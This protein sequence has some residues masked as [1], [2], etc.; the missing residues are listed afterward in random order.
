MDQQ[1]FLII[2]GKDIF[3]H[4]YPISPPEGYEPNGAF[5]DCC[6]FH[7]NV[8]ADT[9]GFLE[10]FPNC[11]EPHRSFAK[12]PF[13]NAG[14]YKDLATKVVNLVSYTEFKI[15]NN[16]DDPQWYKDVTDYIEWIVYSFGQPSVGLDKYLYHLKYYVETLQ[17]SFTDY[18]ADKQ[19]LLLE[20]INGL[21][22]PSKV[23]VP[24]LNELYETYNKWLNTFPFGL[25]Y[26]KN[27]KEHFKNNI[28]ILADKSEYNPYS[29]LSR[30]KLQTRASLIIFLTTATKELLK[31]IDAS[32]LVNDGTIEDPDQHAIAVIGQEHRVKQM[33]LVEQY[34][35][36]EMDYV[37]VLKKWLKN[38]VAYFAKISPLLHQKYNQSKSNE[39][40]TI[41][42]SDEIKP[43]AGALAQLGFG[44]Y[45]QTDDYDHLLLEHNFDEAWSASMNQVNPGDIILVT[46]TVAFDNAFFNLA[47]QFWAKDK[48]R[49]YRFVTVS[50]VGFAET[51]YGKKD[52]SKVLKYCEDLNFPLDD[53]EKLTVSVQK[54][55]GSS[56]ENDGSYKANG[57]MKED[58][59]FIGHGRSLVWRELEAYLREEG[60]SNIA[61]ETE[62]RTGEHIIDILKG[63]LNKAT[64][65]IVVVTAEDE[66]AA[67]TTRPRQNVVHEI[68]LFQ[69][70]LG[71]E[72][73]AILKQ[74]GTEPFTNNDGLQYIP[75]ADNQIDQTFHRL[76]KALQKAGIPKIKK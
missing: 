49:F 53:K 25:P 13:F 70:R 68:G 60:Y 71:F 65:A 29:G 46:N 73:V 57:T 1:P 54:R 58:C 76:S 37:K 40:M 5:P 9:K 66:T 16:L 22:S 75:F 10:K 47:N 48:A 33:S 15:R 27:L 51:I 50:I 17:K 44:Y 21:L 56:L 45:L 18:P 43:L 67:G 4:P 74:N 8:V 7:R 23:E 14:F 24:D 41:K 35:K 12:K 64:F 55:N 72:K 19:T 6:Q 28:P 62:S 61:F 42:I 3:L 69:G 34:S 39:E 20:Y 36:G 26:F 63:F 32:E 2:E 38:E 30:A 11:C 31:K 52:F 59:I